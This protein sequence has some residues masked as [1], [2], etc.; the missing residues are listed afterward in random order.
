MKWAA[1]FHRSTDEILGTK[2]SMK[3]YASAM[4]AS[5]YLF[6]MGILGKNCFQN[7][8]FVNSFTCVTSLSCSRNVI[9]GHMLV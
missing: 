1:A 7:P 3:F 5:Y 8:F 9:F 2:I 6:Q 4:R